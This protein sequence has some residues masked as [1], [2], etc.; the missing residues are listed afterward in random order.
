M[1]Q[2]NLAQILDLLEGCS[3]DDLDSIQTEIEFI[4]EAMGVE[5]DDETGD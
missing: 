1:A 3:L 5:D 2:S 4:R